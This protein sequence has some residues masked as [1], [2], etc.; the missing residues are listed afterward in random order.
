[1]LHVKCS[2]ANDI[3][4]ATGAITVLEPV[5]TYAILEK[6]RICA[7]LDNMIVLIR[8]IWGTR[9][10]V[11]GFVRRKKLYIYIHSR[12]SIASILIWDPVSGKQKN[13]AEWLL[14]RKRGWESG[15]CLHEYYR[16]T[17]FSLNVSLHSPHGEHSLTKINFLR[18]FHGYWMGVN[19]LSLFSCVSQH[20]SNM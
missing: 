3:F 1:M 4:V 12:K 6:A 5:A 13:F 10:S 19:V 2:A 14:R 16:P 8:P 20:Q 11:S 17:T 9:P 18:S 15:T 7:K